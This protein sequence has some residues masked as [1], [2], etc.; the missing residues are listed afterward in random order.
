VDRRSF[1]GTLAAGLLAAPLGAGA[2]QAGKVYRIAFLGST[3][4]SGYASQVAA[5]RGGLRDFG[6]RE[7]RNLVIDFRWALGHYE[8][9]PKLAAELVPL[10]C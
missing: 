10:L 4:P 1:I 8:R 9:L 5:F 6:Y 2:Q 7:G 3:S